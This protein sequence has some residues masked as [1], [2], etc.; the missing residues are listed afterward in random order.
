MDCQEIIIVGAGITGLYL[1]NRLLKKG[2]KANIIE[3][4]DY[5]GGRLIT[6]KT[7]VKGTEYSMEC[8]GARY[9]KNH[10]TVIKLIEEFDL[11]N[12]VYPLSKEVIFCPKKKKKYKDYHL[13]YY[14]LDQILKDFNITKNLK[15]I[16]FKEWLN[17]NIDKKIAEY[18]IDSYPYKDMFKTNTYD[19][20]RLYKK[21]LNVKNDFF[22]LGC[23]FTE[24]INRMV[25]ENKKLGGKIMLNC[26][27]ININK[28]DKYNYLVETSQNILNCNKVIFTGQRPDLLNIPCLTPLKDK[29][30]SV[31][32]SQLSRIYFIFDTKKCAWFKNI[33]KT[34][35]DS[36][37]S[38]FIP[39]N[40]ETGLVMISYT[41]EYN[42]KYLK[43]LEDKNPKTFVQF[44]LDE[45][46]DIFNINEIPKPL[47]YK[48]FHWKNGVGYWKVGS[49][50]LKIH[51]EIMKPYKNEN[52]YICSENY[53]KD[54]QV[55]IEGGLDSANK[56]LL[57]KD[58][59]KN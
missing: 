39:I 49:D 7:K 55:W 18:I 4:N 56:L 40:Y 48:N 38:Y 35:T 45:C 57:N 26:K 42:A 47:W 23:G 14:Y 52:I 30:N 9:S 27:C 31:G 19:V 37:I 11:N 5:I 20:L 1:Q 51:K 50:S 54:Y 24:L 17:V 16:N 3:K 2:I 46:K 33:K 13:P 25:K 29:L 43:N 36:K 32:N 28:N 21:D 41:D 12:Q 8:G 6:Y 59:I 22:V 15:D 34:I 58:F 53:S 10:K 44:I